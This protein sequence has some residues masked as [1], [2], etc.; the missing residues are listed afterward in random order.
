MNTKCRKKFTS[1]GEDFFFR[2]HYVFWKKIEKSETD[3]KRRSF[4]ID[5]NIFGDGKSKMRQIQNEDFFFGLCPKFRPH[6]QI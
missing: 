2:D 6:S 1:L 4:F 3:S 5:I